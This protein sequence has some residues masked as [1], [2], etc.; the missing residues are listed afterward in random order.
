MTT[1][2]SAYI[3]G[4]GFHVPEK[5]LTN[6]DLERM[7]ETSDEWITSR[8]G[9]RERHIAEVGT[10]SSDLALAAARKALNAAGVLPSELTHIIC[11]TPPLRRICSPRPAIPASFA[12]GFR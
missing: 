8:T 9:I 4:L 1:P 5:V 2:S 3:L 7:V 10:G 12:E 11:P 6:R